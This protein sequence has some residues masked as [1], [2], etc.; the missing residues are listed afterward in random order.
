MAIV[1]GV[2]LS[3][4]AADSHFAFPSPRGPVGITS[5][6]LSCDDLAPPP[7]WDILDAHVVMAQINAPI[8]LTSPRVIALTQRIPI[9]E[10]NEEQRTL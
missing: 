7:P 6:S 3:L 8:T 4:S 2:V 9:L 1:E 10:G 5:W